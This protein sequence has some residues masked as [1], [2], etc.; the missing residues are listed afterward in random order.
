LRGCGACH[1]PP[2]AKKKK[3]KRSR[4]VKTKQR[5]MIEQQLNLQYEQSHMREPAIILLVITYRTDGTHPEITVIP[6][7]CSQTRTMPSNKAQKA[8]P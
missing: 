1:P 8:T 5:R 4:P 6:T 2:P 7:Y 3:G